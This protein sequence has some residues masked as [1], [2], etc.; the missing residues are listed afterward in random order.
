MLKITTI[1]KKSTV[2]CRNLA[3][4][5]DMMLFSYSG[6]REYKCDEVVHVG[7]DAISSALY[8]TELKENI[9]V[10]E[11]F[12]FLRKIAKKS[13]TDGMLKLSLLWFV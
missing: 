8:E 5:H 2:V 3:A 11:A 13:L 9:A 4:S 1:F 7:A 12:D 10:N 6:H